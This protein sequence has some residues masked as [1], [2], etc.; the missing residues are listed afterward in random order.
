MNP[1]QKGSIAQKLFLSSSV[2]ICIFVFF[3][4][5]TLW[6]IQTIS[7]LTRT[8]YNHPLVVSNA[9]LQANISITKM[10]RNMKDVVLFLDSSRVQIS[11]EKVNFE[12]NEV[13]HYLNI[14]KG[15]IL[16][17]EGKILER[18]ARKLFKNWKPIRDE[19][20][21]LVRSDHR[22]KAAEIT[23]GKG[24]DHVADLER[25][26]L[27][28]TNY[29]RAKAKT[30]MAESENTHDRMMKTSIAFLILV[31]MI[32]SIISYFTTRNVALAE[33]ELRES[34]QLLVNAI[35]YAPIG[36]VLVEPNGKF[37][38]VNQAYCKI[39][40]Y[41]EQELLK[42]Q[43][44]DITVSDDYDAG[45]Q[46][47]EELIDGKSNKAEI[48]NRYLKKNG[49]IINV[50][51]ST[52]LLRDSNENP[53][54]FFTQAQDITEK[55]RA[56]QK[57]AASLIEKE[58]LL[59]EVHHRV[60]NNM[61]M[62][63]SIISLQADKISNEKNKQPLIDS[64]N[65]IRVMSLV[66]ESL[67][68]TENFAQLDLDSYFSE[69]AKQIESAYSLNETSIKLII[70]LDPIVLDLDTLIV[71][72]LI[73][74]ELVTNSIKYA[75]PENKEGTIRISV[76][77]ISDEKAELAV[78]DNGVGLPEGFDIKKTES[79]GLR[80]VKILSEGQLDGTLSLNQ[81]FGVLYTIC[82]PIK[83]SEARS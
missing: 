79:L 57:I 4:I 54:Y 51:L 21:S 15:T 7:G 72:G 39:T 43:F 26:M 78:S 22:E 27:G 47:I 34:R 11:I 68:K 59:K 35:D 70:K 6:D 19:V 1:F 24:A 44:Q 20:I 3:G 46:V 10:H 53:L 14:V 71:C 32:S 42:M 38:R 74:N 73:T 62:I 61:Q 69:F 80:I 16:G 37:F 5:Y 55:K 9:A 40:G 41:S 2:L 75:F 83:D 56:E 45:S 49:K 33:K 81:N 67:Y 82:F 65:R 25:E 30:F 31:V 50:S 17:E 76:K 18:K 29:A 13:Y 64:I 63:Q 8:I 48:E 23:I 58:T 77:K 28:L 52:S 12:E 36:M 66:H 60:K